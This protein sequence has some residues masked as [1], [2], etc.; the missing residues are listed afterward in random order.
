MMNMYHPIKRALL[1]VSNKTGLVKFA[2][3][4]VKLNIE[5][6]STGGTSQLLKSANINH[7][8]VEEITGLPNLLDGRVKTLH[9][10]LHGGILAKRDTHQDEI[11]QLNLRCID[12]V[13]VNFYP[14]AESPTVENIDIGG[15]TMIR[16]AAKNFEWV[17]ALTDPADYDR[18]TNILHENGGLTLSIR[19]E[20]AQ[21]A[22]AMTMRYDQL[23][24]QY[25]CEKNKSNQQQIFLQL[26]KTTD[27]RYGE[28]PHQK[29][30]AYRINNQINNK[31]NKNGILSAHQYQGKPLSY[32]NI[33]DADAAIACVGE[34]SL[35]TAVIVKHANPCGIASA[36]T[37]DTAYRR[38]YEADSQSAFGGVAA[39]NKICTADIA[40]AI[41]EIFMEVVIAP[42]Y[43]EEALVIFASKPNLRILS[44]DYLSHPDE[45]RFITGGVLLQEKNDHILRVDDLT[46][47]TQLAPDSTAINDLLFAWQGVKHIK[48]NAILIAK[49]NQTIGIGAGQVSRIGAVELAVKKAGKKIA[50]AVLA[51]DAF[52]PFADSI[53]CLAKTNIRAIIQPGGSVRDEEVIARCN[54][55]GIAMVVTGK[56]CFKH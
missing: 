26:E 11:E 2:E 38:A 49:E 22:F 56:R 12:L 17:A 16:A 1:S 3:Q 27:L 5:I 9:P 34:F 35:P 47:V 10:H 24:Y 51:S 46:V 43:T 7:L 25:F 23:I 44:L 4:L 36:E 54:Q 40:K 39:L 31:I 13:V 50:H 33:I 52:F 18:I 21:K 42:A 53:D 19:Q 14:F 28:N 20:L 6:I 30:S 45:M 15:P 37:I 8:T 48:S 41:T 32:N 29:A 55:L